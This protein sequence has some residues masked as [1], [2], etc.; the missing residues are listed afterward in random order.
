MHISIKLF[1]SLLSQN[2]ILLQQYLAAPLQL[3]F[4]KW[5]SYGNCLLHPKLLKMILMWELSTP[6]WLAIGLQRM[7]F[8][9]SYLIHSDYVWGAVHVEATWCT[10]D[11][12]RIYFSILNMHKFCYAFNTIYNCEPAANNSFSS[13]TARRTGKWQANAL[14]ADRQSLLCLFFIG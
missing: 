7:G 11:C 13:W 8:G 2:K 4:R 14:S 12:R 9:G 1:V 5:C 10:V 6:R 3:G